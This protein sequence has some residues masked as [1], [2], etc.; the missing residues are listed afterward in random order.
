[1]FDKLRGCKSDSPLPTTISTCELADAFADYFVQKIKT[2]RNELDSQMPLLNLPTNDP[3]TEPSFCSF[4]PV[5]I[6]R[7]E[8]TI[9]KSSQKA[10]SL[11]P[12]PT[13]LFVECYKPTASCSDSHYQPVSA[14]WCFPLYFLKR[15]L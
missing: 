10:C 14:D 5:S 4:Q 2:V 15:P 11:D 1:M 13:S 7:V 8:N 3:Y 6:Q 9:L 12:I